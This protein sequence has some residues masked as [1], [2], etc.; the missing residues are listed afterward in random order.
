MS[1]LL[2]IEIDS[3]GTYTVA[4]CNDKQYRASRPTKEEAIEA[5]RQLIV[6][7]FRDG[8]LAT[9]TIPDHELPSRIKH[10]GT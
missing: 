4:W 8:R 7:G 1:V 3:H 2:T 10:Q 5:V 6:Q 9:I